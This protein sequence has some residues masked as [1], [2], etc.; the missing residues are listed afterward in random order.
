[1]AL[2]ERPSEDLHGEIA[3][4]EREAAPLRARVGALEARI[5]ALRTELRRRERLETLQ[6]RRQTRAEL[7]EM[8]TLEAALAAPEPLLPSGLSLADLRCFRDSATEVI[9]GY[10][11]AAHPSLDLTDGSQVR[12][13][14]DL[15][16]AR[17]LWR[18]GW[19]PGTPATRGVRIHPLGSR[20]ER[21]VPASEIRVRTG[22]P[23]PR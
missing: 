12:T 8:P 6:G 23:G 16:E 3:G 7:G 13:V 21:V 11:A 9:L 2:S 1:V 10:A 20:A 22:A 17:R 15:D 4:L 5:E 19:E 18:D 14:T